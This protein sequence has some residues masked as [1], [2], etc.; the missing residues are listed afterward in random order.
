MVWFA[1]IRVWIWGFIAS[2]IVNIITFIILILLKK[3]TH[4]FV[5]FKARWKGVPISLFFFDNRTVDWKVDKPDAGLVEDK[6]YGTY[7]VNERGSYVDK[8]TRNIMMC[9][10]G[11][12]GA[13]ASVKAFKLAQDLQVAL[14]DEKQMAAIR[15]MVINDEVKDNMS[16]DGIKESINFSH[17]RSLSNTILPHNIMSKIEKTVA[18]RMGNYGKVPAGT[19]II[20]VAAILGATVLAAILLKMYR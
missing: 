15:E 8:S 5:E 13:G 10:D 11:G 14:K 12:F 9:F 3:W 2:F 4:A 19:I 1:D 18:Q 16:L 6:E 17:L 7:I 20:I